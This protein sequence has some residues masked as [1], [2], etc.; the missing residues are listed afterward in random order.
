T[1]PEGEAL[2][3][4][5]DLEN[6]RPIRWRVLEPPRTF[7][8]STHDCV[9]ILRGSLASRRK[10]I[11]RLLDPILLLRHR[12]FRSELIS[13][14][15]D[16]RKPPREACAYKVNAVL[17]WGGGGDTAPMHKNNQEPC[18]LSVGRLD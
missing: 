16:D 5:G 14:T 15:I 12:V 9:L 18:V 8:L 17:F 11:G 2:R 7:P 3:F 6:H 4:L 13:L 10:Q 1:N